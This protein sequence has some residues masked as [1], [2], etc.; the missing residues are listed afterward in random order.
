MMSA[1]ELCSPAGSPG[2]RD[3]STERVFPDTFIAENS[4]KRSTQKECPVP[5]PP[6]PAEENNV[7][8]GSE[9][10]ARTAAPNSLSAAG[11]RS[12]AGTA[13]PSSLEDAE[14]R[15]RGRTA[16]PNSP[17]VPGN[18]SRAG[19]AAPNSLGT[20]G[21]R[22]GPGQPLPIPWGLL[23]SEP[24][25]DSRSQVPGDGWVQEPGRDS[26]S[27]RSQFPAGCRAGPA[28]PNSLGAVGFRSRAG[29]AGPNSRPAAGFRNWA[30]TAAPAAPN[31]R[32]VSGSAPDALRS[33][34]C[35]RPGNS[36][37]AAEVPRSSEMQIAIRIC[38]QIA[39][40]PL[41]LPGE[42]A[43]GLSARSRSG[44]GNGSGSS[45]WKPL[46]GKSAQLRVCV[47]H[48]SRKRPG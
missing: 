21:F 15:S 8:S 1:K 24:G 22:A 14:F 40:V 16:A 13:V 45:H 41:K 6:V 4:L 35:R 48:N 18:R 38:S 42:R 5:S 9:S 27:C 37:P 43:A 30:G 46:R 33:R 11:N 7:R 31:S 47:K 34:A 29:T 23:G 2:H 44:N 20:A 32:P 19:T 28:A 10:R 36:H 12:R 39:A 3:D 17:T 25:R 26:R